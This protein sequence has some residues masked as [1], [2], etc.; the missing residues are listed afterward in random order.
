M[1][2]EWVLTFFKI[3]YLIIKSEALVM[4]FLMLGCHC[5]VGRQRSSKLWYSSSSTDND[6][7]DTKKVGA[8]EDFYDFLRWLERYEMEAQG[9]D[10]KRGWGFRGMH[11]WQPPDQQQMMMIHLKNLYIVIPASAKKFYF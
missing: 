9:V 5:V 4:M 2:R 10:P 3:E 1:K 7:N 8:E 11:K 6:T